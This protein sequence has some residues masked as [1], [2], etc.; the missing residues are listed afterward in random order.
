M[1][2]CRAKLSVGEA[3]AQSMKR[4]EIPGGLP[5]SWCHVIIL[6]DD[7]IQSVVHAVGARPS[8]RSHFRGRT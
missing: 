4:G 8:G 2:I 1:R 6:G 7:T 5:C 3:R